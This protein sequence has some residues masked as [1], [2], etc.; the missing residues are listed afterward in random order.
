MMVLGIFILIDASEVDKNIIFTQV[1]VKI[2][3]NDIMKLLIYC[4]SLINFINQ[5]E[6]NYIL[7]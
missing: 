6:S 5:K 4:D 3:C 7:R 1:F 2:N